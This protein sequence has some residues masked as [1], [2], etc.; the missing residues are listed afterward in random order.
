[1]N[2][3]W[4]QF[5]YRDDTKGDSFKAN[6]RFPSMSNLLWARASWVV[7]VP[8]PK[9]NITSSSKIK[10]HSTLGSSPTYSLISFRSRTGRDTHLIDQALEH[11]DFN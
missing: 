7:N 4:I 3:I 8:L 5:P 1:M 10:V 6:S 11:I 9:L 2:L